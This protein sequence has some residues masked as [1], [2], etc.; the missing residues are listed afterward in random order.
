VRG[1]HRALWRAVG[2]GGAHPS[3]RLRTAF[4]PH[5]L[6]PPLPPLLL[7]LL[8][9]LPLLLPPLQ[10][11]R[12]PLRRHSSHLQQPLLLIWRVICVVW[13]PTASSLCSLPRA[14]CAESCLPHHTHT[15]DTGVRGRGKSPA[16]S[17]WLVRP[18]S[19]SSS[20]SPL[21]NV[22]QKQGKQ[23]AKELIKS[24]R[25]TAAPQHRTYSSSIFWHRM[26]ATTTTHTTQKKEQRKKHPKK[27]R[28]KSTEKSGRT[29][30]R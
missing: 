24:R 14:F 1:L 5:S 29:G 2:S 27:A 22:T 30:N 11:Q 12:R 23:Q 9:P 20:A 8:L 26:H 17:G 4:P 15:H 28:E 6:P 19:S 16:Q 25:G 3:L 18:E 7:R 10:P 13:S 21:S